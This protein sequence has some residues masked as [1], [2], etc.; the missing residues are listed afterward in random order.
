MC[1]SISQ[2]IIHSSMLNINF[3]WVPKAPNHNRYNYWPLGN[4]AYCVTSPCLFKEITTKA[5]STGEGLLVV[6]MDFLSP[7]VRLEKNWLTE[8]CLILQFND[9]IRDPSI[10]AKLYSKSFNQRKVK[11]SK[12]YQREFVSGNN[13]L[14]VHIQM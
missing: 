3:I 2:V 4:Y 6:L 12:Y 1:A 5:K 8:S 11:W 7:Y 10:Y 13:H 9:N 14:F